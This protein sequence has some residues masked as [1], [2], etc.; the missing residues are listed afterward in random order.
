MRLLFMG[1]SPFAV[2]TLHSLIA[3]PEHEVVAVVTQPD[4]PQGRGG[5]VS[6]TPVKEA[7]MQAG[8]PLFQPEKVRAKEFVQIVR[9]MAPET[10]VVAAFGQIIPQRILDIPRFGCLNVH[11]S[12]LPRWRGAAPMQYALMSGDAETGVTTMMMDAGLDTGDIL[13]QASLPLGDV[14]NWGELEPRLAALGADLL[15]QTLDALGRGNCPRRVQNPALVTLAP[16]LPPDRGWLDWNR[17]ARELHNLVRG[18]TPRP[19]AFTFW[20]GKRLKV[21]RTEVV[22][23]G[24]STPGAIENIGASGILVGTNAGAI[25]LRDVQPESKGRMAADAW[26]RGARLAPGQRFDPRLDEEGP[27][28]SVG[29]G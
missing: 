26:A 23:E 19:G 7:A 6:A 27:T 22:E 8:L 9:A 13:L 14:E 28:L 25:L 11:G 5:K 4:R 20:Q 10:I 1:T 2:P 15:L 24:V 29:S 16:S 17:P 12:L 3:S 21:L 18:V